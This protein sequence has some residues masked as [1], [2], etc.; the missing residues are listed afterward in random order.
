MKEKTLGYERDAS[1]TGE[2][3]VLLEKLVSNMR[4]VSQRRESPE[5]RISIM[6]LVSIIRSDSPIREASLQ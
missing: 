2:M 3:L 1:L 5:I 4:R 6:R